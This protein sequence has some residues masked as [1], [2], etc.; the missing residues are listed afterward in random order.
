[1][2]KDAIIINGLRS[3]KE[4]A[5]KYL[6]DQ[7]YSILCAFARQYVNDFDVAEMIVSDVIYA[8]W[9]NRSTQTIHLTLRGY[10]LKAVKNGCLNYLGRLS[11]QVSLDTH[12]SADRIDNEHPLEKLLEQELDHRIETCIGALPSLT[13]RIFTLSRFE[14][15]KYNEIAQQLNISVDVVKYHIKSA[16][17]KLREDLKEYLD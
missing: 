17:N 10:L 2:E 11:K 5:Y 3:G 1:M 9:K 15:L 8:L 7:H 16:L 13:R 12:R 4:E 14:D 6:Y